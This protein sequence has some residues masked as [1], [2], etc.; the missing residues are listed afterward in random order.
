M[1]IRRNQLAGSRVR[2]EA[3]KG[4]APR[5]SAGLE[6]FLNG[7]GFSGLAADLPK[8]AALYDRPASSFFNA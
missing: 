4:C 2:R 6:F 7:P 1:K 8:R 5:D 3:R